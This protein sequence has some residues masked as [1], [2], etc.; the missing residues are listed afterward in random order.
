[1]L[2]MMMNGP[3]CDL[4]QIFFLCLFFALSTSELY[5]T[6]KNKFNDEMNMAYLKSTLSVLVSEGL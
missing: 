3:L 4:T 6:A 1:M 5:S 2:C